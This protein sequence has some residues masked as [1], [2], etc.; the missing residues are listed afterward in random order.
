MTLASSSDVEKE[1]TRPPASPT[2]STSSPRHQEAALQSASNH[3][4]S[5][6]HAST[7]CS[8]SNE[9]ITTSS[10]VATA[11][12]DT[13]D[14]T[15][16]APSQETLRTS[17]SQ[18]TISTS[19]DS[20]TQERA[21]RSRSVTPTP[22]IS[23]EP[24]LQWTADMLSIPESEVVTSDTSLAK[25]RGSNTTTTSSVAFP[26]DDDSLDGVFADDTPEEGGGAD[27]EGGWA[28]SEPGPS[29]A[30]PVQQTTTKLTSPTEAD[31]VSDSC[32]T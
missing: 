20:L 2:A 10:A 4:V 17:N 11:S 31:T 5:T 21:S 27:S 3:T 32:Q 19:N 29:S 30:P 18:L 14:A 22:A 24:D 8:T 28:D 23:I 13:S 26:S 16:C 7:K 12:S 9:T 25:A 6:T 1:L 15:P